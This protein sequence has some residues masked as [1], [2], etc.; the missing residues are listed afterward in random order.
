[1]RLLE[2]T[3]D[4]GGANPRRSVTESEPAAR[5]PVDLEELRARIYALERRVFQQNARISDNVSPADLQKLKLRIQ[6]LEHSLN[7]ELWAARQREYTLLEIL[8]KPPL[9]QVARERITHLWRSEIPAMSRWLQQAIKH[10]WRELR[11]VW[12]PTLVAAWQESL[13]KA[14]R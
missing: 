13:D 8:S 14:R 5:R 12:W 9:K 1:M 10:C 3:C 2:F 11:H 4:T 6:R 7:G